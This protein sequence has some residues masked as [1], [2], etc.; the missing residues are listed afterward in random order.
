MSRQLKLIKSQL[1]YIKEMIPEQTSTI[2][3][4]I[5]NDLMGDDKKA[6]S[7][8]IETLKQ[9]CELN[10]EPNEKNCHFKTLFYYLCAAGVISKTEVEEDNVTFNVLKITGINNNDFHINISQGLARYAL[11]TLYFAKAK[12][13]KNIDLYKS[14]HQYAIQCL[15][16][17][18]SFAFCIASYE[19]AH[20]YLEGNK[21]FKAGMSSPSVILKK[22]YKKYSYYIVEAINRQYSPA[23]ESLRKNHELAIEPLL[24]F[25]ELHEK[26]EGKNETEAF[27]LYLLA[28]NINRKN[29]AS[30]EQEE[31]LAQV[32]NK[33]YSMYQEGRGVSKNEALAKLHFEAYQ[34]HTK[35]LSDSNGA[36]F[37]E[38][39]RAYEEMGNNVSAMKYHET[40][41]KYYEIAVSL[42][43]YQSY[44]NLGMLCISGGFGKS[45][46]KIDFSYGYS[47]LE[48]A[49]Q[50]GIFEAQ[51]KLIENCQYDT[52]QK[53]KIHA[54]IAE[55]TTQH[56]QIVDSQ[57]HLFSTLKQ[58]ETIE[59]YPE[60]NNL[61]YLKKCAVRG[62]KGALYELGNAYYEGNK[63]GLAKDYREASKHFK[64]WIESPRDV[65]SDECWNEPHRRIWSSY[66]LGMIYSAMVSLDFDPCKGNI[67][68]GE[69]SSERN[70]GVPTDVKEAIHWFNKALEECS[71]FPEPAIAL[72][73]IYF[74]GKKV[75]KNEALA[76][77]LLTKALGR[78]SRRAEFDAEANY[79][80]GRLNYLGVGMNKNCHTALTCLGD[81]YLK[82]F[83][84]AL[85]WFKEIIKNKDE[86]ERT[87]ELRILL[88][89]F[90]EVYDSREGKQ[91]L[92]IRDVTIGNNARSFEVIEN[93]IKI[94]QWTPSGLNIIE[95]TVNEHNKKCGYNYLYFAAIRYGK[96]QLLEFLFENNLAS[97]RNVMKIES[98]FSLS[99]LYWNGL[100]MAIHY[101]Q[102]DIFKYIIDR[103]PALA[104]ECE[105]GTALHMIIKT[106]KLTQ[107]RMNMIEML[108]RHGIDLE[109]TDKSLKVA[110][111]YLDAIK[112]EA[113]DALTPQV[114]TFLAKFYALVGNL[115]FVGVG[116]SVRVTLNA[117]EDNNVKSWYVKGLNTCFRGT[118]F[119][120]MLIQH[121]QNE[122]L[123][124]LIH[125]LLNNKS[126]HACLDLKNSQG[127]STW[128]M[129]VQAEDHPSH[130]KI[131]YGIARLLDLRQ[132]WMHRRKDRKSELNNNDLFTNLVGKSKEAIEYT[133]KSC[134]LELE[135]ITS[136]SI[137]NENERKNLYCQFYELI[138]NIGALI[139]MQNTPCYCP[140]ESYKLLRSIPSLAQFPYEIENAMQWDSRYFAAQRKCSDLFCD[141]YP[142]RIS[143]NKEITLDESI[144]SLD[145]DIEMEDASGD[146]A[147]EH[148]RKNL[149]FSISKNSSKNSFLAST[150]S[151]SSSSSSGSSSSSSS[152]SSKD[153]S[154]E[155]LSKTESLECQTIEFFPD[156]HRGNHPDIDNDLRRLYQQ[157]H[158][159]CAGRHNDPRFIGLTKQQFGMISITELHSNLNK[160]ILLNGVKSSLN[161]PHKKPEDDFIMQTFQQFEPWARSALNVPVENLS[162]Q[163][164]KVEQERLQE[165]LNAINDQ[166][167]SR[168]SEPQVTPMETDD[169]NVL[170]KSNNSN[171]GTVKPIDQIV[172]SSAS[173]QNEAITQETSDQGSDAIPKNLKRYVRE[174]EGTLSGNLPNNNTGSSQTLVQDVTE[175]L[176][177]K[178]KQ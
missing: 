108:F 41:V 154:N 6:Q 171:N 24:A 122:I 131:L 120:Q 17:A 146:R 44:Y 151:S 68:E 35:G 1:S 105:D 162:M 90:L 40:A 117:I 92:I 175:P 140:V 81:S 47:C 33:L 142:K 102:H 21:F 159:S 170:N 150:R 36:L 125:F 115:Y 75:P 138:F 64:A 86:K 38:L 111:E 45:S 50:Y 149:I 11:A 69:T 156:V 42:H 48:K 70:Y 124:N 152:S 60:R 56:P 10:V 51:L 163:E 139:G 168:K 79:I 173:S 7:A 106:K 110:T 63:Y 127:K 37:Y 65:S 132:Q 157:F 97:T 15:E 155:M 134:D 133:I 29:V 2:W 123:R 158:L 49:A 116:H 160:K 20:L 93:I 71:K 121:K 59:G 167:T 53:L 119:I 166:L 107:S 80:Y 165:R 147:T 145:D 26:G 161:L 113:G 89:G 141:I 23:L 177:K 72:A 28:V 62:H 16:G 94:L 143:K 109:A 148:F 4:Q 104:K 112:E 130:M 57:W 126:Y 27:R 39:G 31:G 30:H 87:E 144:K 46:K 178:L 52:K 61:Y 77:E 67:Q 118:P 22:D 174:E 85:Q 129:M 54:Q 128:E 32:H 73:K 74:H 91:N 153:C 101:D 19:L 164:L 99:A 14:Y 3:H 8:A 78:Y 82:N 172:L 5:L 103:D 76:A 18:A 176:K 13:S 12:G 66:R 25:A 96:Y 34:A 136:A 9:Y 83:E 58:N 88:T 43:F 84:P 169:S 114:K 55:L 135:Y 95:T 98:N 137:K 100:D